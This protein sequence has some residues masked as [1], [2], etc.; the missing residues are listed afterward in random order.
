PARDEA[1]VIA[2]SLGSLLRQDYPGT[3]AVVVVD[4]QSRDATA[5]AAR[6]CAASQ[7][8]ADRLTLVPGRS[9]PAGW[10]GK[11]WAMQQGIAHVENLPRPAEYLLFTDADIAYM[12]DALRTLVARARSKNLVLASLMAK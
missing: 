5:E 1:D 9:L 2:A 12:P 8:A 4:D 6:A 11:L 3:F 7:N 10:S